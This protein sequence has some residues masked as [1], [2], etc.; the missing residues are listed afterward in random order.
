MTAAQLR[1]PGST[2]TSAPAPPGRGRRASA[3]GRSHRTRRWRN[4]SPHR[5]GDLRLDTAAPRAAGG[6]GAAHRRPRRARRA[7]H[8]R[9][10]VGDLPGSRP[11]ARR[12]D[13]GRLTADRPA[14]RPAARARR[15]R[16]A[17][18]RGGQ[19]RAAA[20]RRPAGRGRSCAT[21]APSTCSCP[22]SSWPTTRSSRRCARAGVSLFVVDE[23]H[24]VSE[25]GHDF[26]PDYLRL[27]PVIE[28][29][30]HPPVVALTATA[31]PPTRAD[32]A[33]R[34]GLRDPAQVVASFDRPEPAPGRAPVPRRR[35]APA[36]G[37]RAHRRAVARNRDR[38][39]WSTAPPARTPWPTPRSCAAAVSGRRPTTRG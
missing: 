4:C 1:R 6:D 32:I 31:A 5:R 15:H 30:G 7:A 16:G 34:L 22:P 9:R 23:A 38:S 13:R 11:A 14:A 19:L 20:P 26:R 12:P 33:A 10:Q 24:C 2:R 18:R 39:A 17:R 35:P 25:W 37:G 27:G 3:W 21:A 29:L 28:R 36:R 8:R